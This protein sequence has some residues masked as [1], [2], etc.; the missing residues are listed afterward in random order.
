M[1][2]ADAARQLLLN[3]PTQPRHTFST[4][5]ESRGSEFALAQARDMARGREAAHPAL[6]ISGGPK[7]GK[8]HLLLAIG[9]AAAQRGIPALYTSCPQWLL[10]TSGPGGDAGDI[11]RRLTGAPFLLMDDVDQIAG[12]KAAQETLY[13]VF[14][15]FQ[16]QGKNLVFS[17]RM[18][19]HRLA[20]TENFLKSRLQW[21]MTVE[22]QPFDEKS[23]GRLLVKLACDRGLEIPQKAVDYLLLR[24][25]RDFPT[26]E[27]AVVRINET[28]LQEKRKVTIPL[29][30]AALGLEG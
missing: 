23:A 19:P 18:P 10:A 26:L 29:V 30:R 8:T 9:N 17:G 16:S 21:G 22:L 20:A 24:L 25:A 4:F 7:L 11:V 15:S 3:F 2:E 5:I 27:N 12:H 1:P 14:N 13:T 28:S 6:Y